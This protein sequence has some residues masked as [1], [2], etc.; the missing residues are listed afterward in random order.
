MALTYYERQTAITI[1]S[2]LMYLRC[3]SSN[4]LPIVTGLF[5][6]AEK[7]SLRAIEFFHSL[8]ISTSYK[9]IRRLILKDEP[10]VAQPCRGDGGTASESFPAQS[11]A[12]L[13]PIE[14][15]D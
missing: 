4:L 9:T 1:I 10:R 6:S 5:L 2:Q 3:R 15:V 11:L 8:H 14:P 7:C 12:Q 13:L